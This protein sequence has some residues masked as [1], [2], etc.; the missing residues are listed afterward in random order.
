MDDERL[1]SVMAGHGGRGAMGAG[2][3]LPVMVR[4]HM[5]LERRFSEH[6]R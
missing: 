6:A 1:K 5:L 3:V 2:G 4:R